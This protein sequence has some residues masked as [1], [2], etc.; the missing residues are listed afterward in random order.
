MN[1]RSL[2]FNNLP[3]LPPKA[4]VET[5][6]TLSAAIGANRELARL[7][8]YCSLLPDDSI[9]LS[10]IVLKEASASSAIEN[11]I[12]TQDELYRALAG[13]TG[14]V[15]Q[16]TKEVLNYRS[17][18]YIG[19]GAL[20]KK[21]ILSL[22]TI[23][24]IQQELEKN[25]AGIRK[26]PGTSLVN[27]TTGEVIYT[28]PDNPDAIQSLLSN[29]ESFIN[30]NSDIDPLIRMALAH[31]QFESIH[32]FYDG[33][34]RTGRIINVLFLVLNNLIES[35]VL[36]LSSYINRNKAIYYRLIQNVRDIG[37]W[38]GWIL[39]MLKAVE[40]TS[41]ETFMIIS[42]IVELLEKTAA[43]AREKLPTTSYSRELIEA[44]FIQPYTKIDFLVKAGIGE[45]RTASKYLKQLQEIGILESH[46]L[47]KEMLYI[48]TGLYELLKT[49]QS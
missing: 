34:G 26:T 43:I 7:S 27:D 35:P 15:D 36:Y 47:G 28:P 9:L 22:N 48:N 21:G 31:Y 10:S 29:L 11:I 30:Q 19:Y 18:L 37:D 49:D 40:E 20:R 5:K 23:L 41:R 44:V 42:A 13:S 4:E 39:F 32:P 1:D 6:E 3:P 46:K 14:Q 25:N 24:A 17:A 33:N 8:G 38:Q 16:Q 12:T 45:R 2:P